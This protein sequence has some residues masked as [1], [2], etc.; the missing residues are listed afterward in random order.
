M[1]G[2]GPSEW[3][4][5]TLIAVLEANQGAFESGETGEVA[6]RWQFA[7]NDSEVDLDLVEPTGMDRSV[8]QHEVW[9]SG[10][11]SIR[12]SLAAMGGAV[13]RDEEHAVRGAIR[14]FPH[15]LSDKTPERGDA[16]LA[17]TAAEQLR[18]MHVPGGEVCQRAGTRVFV[19][20]VN[21]APWSR[22]Q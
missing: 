11:R 2:E 7:L 15:Y 6:R 4:G 14:F 16:I 5:G 3:F 18:T 21:R 19:F 8:D 17:L 12:G 20:H 22:R 10:S 1:P 13:V 9:P